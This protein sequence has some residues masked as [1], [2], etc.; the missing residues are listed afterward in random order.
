MQQNSTSVNSTTSGNGGANANVNTTAT[1]SSSSSSSMPIEVSS[2]E[3][4]N[5]I[6]AWLKLLRLH[7]YTECL[8]D[9]P[10]KE[11]IEL[12]NDQLESKGVAA[13]GARRKLLKAFDVVKNNLPVV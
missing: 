11:L 7:K 4:L 6:P 3:L 1:T 5:N 2:L 10:W 12:D 9:V 13:L 8:K